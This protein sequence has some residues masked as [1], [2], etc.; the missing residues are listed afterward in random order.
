MLIGQSNDGGQAFLLTST[1]ISDT[2]G[3]NGSL[4]TECYFFFFFLS[5]SLFS[6]LY[7]NITQVMDFNF[8]KG[9][10]R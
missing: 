6:S 10:E 3:R 1:S 8:W 2:N 5:G 7:R 4:I 9:I